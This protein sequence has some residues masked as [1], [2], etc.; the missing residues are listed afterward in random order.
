MVGS[1]GVEPM[2]S[3]MS[4]P[5]F[6]NKNNIKNGLFRCGYMKFQGMLEGLIRVSSSL[7]MVFWGLMKVIHSLIMVN[8]S[9]SRVFCGHSAFSLEENRK[10]DYPD[11]LFRIMQSQG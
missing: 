2:T 8:E 1:V 5:P 11:T 10:S 4:K 3:T 9:E 6:I 7:I